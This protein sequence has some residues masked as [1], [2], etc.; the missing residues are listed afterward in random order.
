MTLSEVE[1]PK[2]MKNYFLSTGQMIKKA[3]IDDQINRYL[4]LSSFVLFVFDYLIW[5]SHLENQDIA[6][7]SLNGLYPIKFIAIILVINTFLAGSSYE[8]EKEISYLLISASI[9]AALLIFVLEVFYL[10]NM[11]TNA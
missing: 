11:S 2:I 10:I 1:G 7:L 4:F 5:K 6:V 3:F 9:F 8:K